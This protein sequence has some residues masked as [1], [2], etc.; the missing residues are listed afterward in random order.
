MQFQLGRFRGAVIHSSPELMDLLAAGVAGMDSQQ[1]P[2]TMLSVI[3]SLS[4][5]PVK[6]EKLPDLLESLPRDSA[7][8]DWLAPTLEALEEADAGGAGIALLACE[9][10]TGP[11][12]PFVVAATAL[13]H[14][15]KVRKDDIV[16][17]GFALRR[18]PNS[19]LEL[20]PRFYRVMCAN[21]VIRKAGCLAAGE[22]RP[23]GV[24]AALANLL[25]R[26]ALNAEVEQLALAARQPVDDPVEFL[27]R[28]EAVGARQR[29]VELWERRRE[30]VD[31]NRGGFERGRDRTLWDLLNVLTASARHQRD[32]SRRLDEEQQ[33][34]GVLALLERLP[35]QRPVGLAL[36]P[37]RT[38]EHLAAHA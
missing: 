23:E 24:R 36:Q 10:A 18:R 15:A 3:A 30:T 31:R 16:C 34:G 21:G 35:P 2:S 1:A 5:A 38:E 13:H 14:H 11:E 28:A 12:A 7:D 19:G 17:S 20:F 6:H 22:L 9:A 32:W 27:M 26:R 25:G 37:P 29:L 8:R 33:A 4:V